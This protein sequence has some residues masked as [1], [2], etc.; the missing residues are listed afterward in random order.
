MSIDLSSFWSWWTTLKEFGLNEDGS[1][2]RLA[3]T[4]S[5]VES[6]QWLASLWRQLGA[7]VIIDGIG[8]VIAQRGESPFILVSSHTDTVPQGGHYDG[9]L[10]VL[11]G[12]VLLEQYRNEKHGLLLVD[13]SCEESSRFSISTVGSRIACGEPLSWDMQDHQGITLKEAAE[14][15]FGGFK[16]SLWHVPIS[17]IDAAIEL[18]MEQGKT[19]MQLDSPVAVVSAIAAPQRWKLT[20]HGQANHSGSTAMG[21][22]HDAVAVAALLVTVIEDLSRKLEE[23]GLRATI[24]HWDAVPGAANVIAGKTTL[25]LDIRAQ[26]ADI[27]GEFTLNLQKYVHR[28]EK[29]RQVHITIN[30]YSEE[31]PA[32]LSPHLSETIC[33]AIA[34]EGLPLTRV[35][36]WPSHDSLVLARHLPTAMVFIRNV[37]GVS[38][39]AHEYCSPDDIACGVQVLRTSVA[40]FDEVRQ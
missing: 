18:H 7:R 34:H 14:T 39:Q 16:A 5:D 33:A 1:L 21:D 10:G 2:S 13:W 27:L 37:S 23:R 24:T 26:F 25:L 36:S 3:L 17:Q 19:L 22:R 12:T 20:I 38:H 8:N 6:R 35:S 31:H 40:M 15:T 32:T 30:R 11:A 28:L 9:I 29:E 4:S